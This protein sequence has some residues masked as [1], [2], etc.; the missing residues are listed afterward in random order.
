MF[1]WLVRYARWLHTGWPAGLVEKTPFAAEDGAT[2][3]AGLYIA[4]DL[5]GIP[6]LKFSSDTGARAVRTILADP[7]FGSR[8]RPDGK[9]AP[10]D[11]VILGAGVAGMAAALEAQKHGLRFEIIEAVEPFSTIVNFPKRKPIY[12]YPTGMTPAG[13]LQFT[14]RSSVKEGLVEELQE[15]AALRGVR[16]RL[17]RCE[18]PSSTVVYCPFETHDDVAG[19]RI[20]NRRPIHEGDVLGPLLRGWNVATSSAIVP[21]AALARVGG[22]D[23]RLPAAHDY[24]LWLCLARAGFRFAAVPDALVIRHDHGEARISADLEARSEGT[25]ARLD[26]KWG[27]L[28]REQLGQRGY[29][30]WRAL[31]RGYVHSMRFARIRSAMMRGDRAAAWGHC[32]ALAR[33]LPG[34]GRYL[35]RGVAL[36][37]L[38]WRGYRTVARLRAPREFISDA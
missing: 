22:F 15:I 10:L 21:R 4:G 27:G 38:G 25:I 13:D 33:G 6:L 3:V 16:P 32:R 19:R 14:S 26:D 2:N 28:V 17:A 31:C 24:D 34:S 30:R 5:T 12:T 9:D 35:V 23:E 8:E 11:L 7:A 20:P 1:S 36:T 37:L 29:E 18:N